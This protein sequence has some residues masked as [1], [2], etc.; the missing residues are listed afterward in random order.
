MYRVPVNKCRLSPLLRKMYR[1]CVSVKEAHG[2]AIWAVTWGP[3]EDIVSGAVDGTCKRWAHEGEA[4]AGGGGGGGA[5]EKS[6][7]GG[8]DAGGKKT[9]GAA[10]DSIPGEASTE[11]VR[12]S[13]V[14]EGHQLGVISA[15]LHPSGNM[16]AT[17]CVDCRIRI[18]DMQEEALTHEIDAGSIE[19]WTASF[20]GLKPH[21]ATGSQRG[22]VN[23]W[24][25]ETGKKVG[26]ME[27]GG[28]FVMSC[29]YSPDGA[30]IGAGCNGGMVSVFD[31]ESGKQKM[32][33]TT[34]HTMPVRSVGFSQDGKLLVSAS[35]DKHVNVYDPRYGQVVASLAG[36]SSWVLSVSMSPD[37]K[38]FAT[39][40]AD[41]KV[42]I[43]DLAMRRCV[44]TF[45][46]HVDQ[47]WAVS[48]NK[49]GTR[50]ASGGDDGMLN[51]FQLE[52]S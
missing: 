32:K 6:E 21:L 4:G 3:G 13:G 19:A 37:G 30:H 25:H 8:S 47:V 12:Q 24:S 18:Y 49:T 26:S 1:R 28:G 40:S 38:R 43:W 33:H 42:K 44:H 23:I 34:S 51:V 22:A 14:F 5:E 35:D 41:N 7:G 27:T 45:D 17:T 36:H 10:P 46:D 2:D 16:V 50:L 31:V 39:G 52:L 29:Q 48:Y 9:D 11:S 15:V 20:S